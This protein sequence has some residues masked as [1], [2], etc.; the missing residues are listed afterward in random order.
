MSVLQVH[1][2]DPWFEMRWAPDEEDEDD[3]AGEAAG[4]LGQ[5]PQQQPQL[6]GA[7]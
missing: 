5:Q 3:E 1:G 7:A 6:N 2:Q 4:E